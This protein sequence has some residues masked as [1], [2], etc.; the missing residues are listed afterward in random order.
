MAR[1]VVRLTKAMEEQALTA[2][3]WAS[4]DAMTDAD[5]ARQ[6]RGHPDAAPILSAR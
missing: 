2:M 5:I 3:D 4:I 6:V 1:R